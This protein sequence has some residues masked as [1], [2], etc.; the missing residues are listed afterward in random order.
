[1]LAICKRIVEAHGGTIT[2]QSAV[3]KDSTFT[4]RIPLNRNANKP[5]SKLDKAIVQNL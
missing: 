2:V 1:M 4:I 3:G 5:Q